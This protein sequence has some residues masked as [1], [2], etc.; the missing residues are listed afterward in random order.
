MI[1][2]H[3]GLISNYHHPISLFSY[4]PSCEIGNP[5]SNSSILQRDYYGSIVIHFTPVEDWYTQVWVHNY[6]VTVLD[7]QMIVIQGKDMIG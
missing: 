3:S 4:A 2:S 6:V 7:R 1:T 5:A